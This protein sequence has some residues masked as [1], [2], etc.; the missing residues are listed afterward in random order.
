MSPIKRRRPP[1][2]RG[3]PVPRPT[4]ITGTDPIPCLTRR[5]SRCSSRGSTRSTRGTTGRRRPNSKSCDSSKRCSS[6]RCSSSNRRS[7]S[8]SN[9]NR[10]SCSSSNSSDSKSCNCKRCSSWNSCN[11][12]SSGKNWN[13][14][15]ISRD[16]NSGSSNSGRRFPRRFRSNF[17]GTRRCRE[18][19]G[20][21]RFL[22]SRRNHSCSRSQPSRSKRSAQFR[23]VCY[24]APRG[25]SVPRAAWPWMRRPWSSSA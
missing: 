17:S 20:N 24:K 9:S 1:Y 12:W 14:S 22:H 7:C 4:S 13:K 15:N 6:K 23:R 8:S 2:C 5:G 21:R 3:V 10:K 18:L 16:S 25:W 19:I 11:S